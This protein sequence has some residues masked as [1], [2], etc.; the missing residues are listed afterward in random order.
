MSPQYRRMSAAKSK[1][2]RGRPRV[3]P[4][5]VQ[6]TVTV[7]ATVLEHVEEILSGLD[8]RGLPSSRHAVLRIAVARGVE[9]M[10]DE[11]AKL[12]L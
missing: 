12:S 9:R 7:D 5:P 11:V 10:R 1:V 8:Q 4:N 2:R 6:V 3:V